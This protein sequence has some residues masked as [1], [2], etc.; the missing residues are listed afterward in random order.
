MKRNAV[1]CILLSP[2]LQIYDRAVLLKVLVQLPFGLNI[3]LYFA[4]LNVGLIM[5]LLFMPCATSYFGGS[6]ATC[7]NDLHVLD[8]QAVT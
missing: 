2:S 8:F 4:G 5:L 1:T 3:V 7:F 6:L